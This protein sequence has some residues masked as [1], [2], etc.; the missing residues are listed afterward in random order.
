MILRVLRWGDQRQ[1]RMLR[2]DLGRIRRAEERMSQ[3]VSAVGLGQPRRR[4]IHQS[5][6][7]Q[8]GTHVQSVRYG[9]REHLEEIPWIN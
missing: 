6:P 4:G 9:G 1:I 3:L 5:Q 2:G 8:R 7:F